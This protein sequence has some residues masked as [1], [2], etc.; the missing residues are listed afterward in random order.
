MEQLS[1]KFIR[2]FDCLFNLFMNIYGFIRIELSSKTMH[3]MY[4]SSHSTISLA[5]LLKEQH[6]MNLIE[7]DIAIQ[8]IKCKT[9][10]FWCAPLKPV[11][12]FKFERIFFCV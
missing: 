7:Y 3:L 4:S 9:G 6:V 1:S 11:A 12:F 10:S 5:T 2:L 8:K